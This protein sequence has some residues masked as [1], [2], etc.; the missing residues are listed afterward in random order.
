MIR[1]KGEAGTGM[2]TFCNLLK[3]YSKPKR[4]STSESPT[5]GD[6]VHRTTDSES[7]PHWH[8]F[9]LNPLIEA[10]KQQT[11]PNNDNGSKTDLHASVQTTSG[12]LSTVP[13]SCPQ[14]REKT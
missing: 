3:F 13:D 5:S 2:E 8:C 14:R 9:Y 4:R 1:T 12:Y 6:S 7:G 10:S 11:P